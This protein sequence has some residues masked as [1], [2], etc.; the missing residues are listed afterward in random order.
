MVDDQAAIKPKGGTLINYLGIVKRNLFPGFFIWDCV[1][2]RKIL[3]AV[4]D[5]AMAGFEV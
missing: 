4:E 1:K 2:P 5:G 3:Q